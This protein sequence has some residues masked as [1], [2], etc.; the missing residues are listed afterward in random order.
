MPNVASV[1]ERARLTLLG[2]SVSLVCN[3]ICFARSFFDE[4]VANLEL[5]SPSK[6][7]Y[8]MYIEAL[9]ILLLMPARPNADNPYEGIRSLVIQA[10]RREWPDSEPVELAL[11]SIIMMAH[12]MRSE[13]AARVSGVDSNDVLFAGENEFRSGGRAFIDQMI[14]RFV[15][16]VQRYGDKGVIAMKT[17]VPIIALHALA[18]LPDVFACDDE[19]ELMRLLKRMANFA[20]KGDSKQIKETRE[21][22]VR[23]LRYVLADNEKAQGFLSAF[24]SA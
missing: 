24:D 15:A 10:I 23:H 12:S 22:T 20:A 18:A 5:M 21:A 1:N 16:A 11:E 6:E 17:K 14:P 8:D 4:F 9:N 19:G 3:V 7:L 2:A 13:Y